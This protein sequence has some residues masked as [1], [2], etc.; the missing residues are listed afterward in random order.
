MSSP[1]LALVSAHPNILTL[2]M[3]FYCCLFG[4]FFQLLCPIHSFF[5][6]YPSTVF[7]LSLVLFIFFFVSLCLTLT[8]CLTV[9]RH[10][11][12]NVPQCSLFYCLL[13]CYQRSTSKSNP[14][15]Y[16]ALLKAMFYFFSLSAFTL[17]SL[18]S[19]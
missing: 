13:S 5:Y 18:Y 9:H 16:Y 15:G 12:C 19:Y 4:R 14:T 1:Y 17:L 8:C 6:L 2:L 3:F 10:M 7:S 11:G